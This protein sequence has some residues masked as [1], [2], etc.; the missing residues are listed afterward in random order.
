[1]SD[2]AEAPWFGGPYAPPIPY[3]E[4][5]AEKRNF[6]GCLNGAIVYG[7]VV[8]LFFKCMGALLRPANRTGGIMKWGLVAHTGAMFSFLTILVATVLDIQS[9]SYI[10]NR[11]FP[12]TDGAPW[13]GPVAYQLAIYSKAISVV[14][15]I[16]FLLNNW[17]ADGLL[18]YRCCVIY[19][20]KYWVIAFP[21]LMYLA[22][23]TL[24]ILF[25]YQSS[26][27]VGFLSSALAIADFGTPLF[28]ISL[29]LNV[30]LTLMIVARLFVHDRRLRKAT[31][32]RVTASGLYKALN[33]ILVESC[34]V[35]A[36][37]FL[38]YMGPWVAGS[39]IANIFFLP[40]T[41]AQVIA[42]FLLVL[43][44]A[45]RTAVTSDTMISVSGPSLYFRSKVE[46]IGGSETLPDAHH[47]GSIGTNGETP[48][49]HYVEDGGT[50]DEISL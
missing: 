23:F 10:D 33:T 43:R 13:A 37:S 26:R 42:P 5:I 24:G 18:L 50:I 36:I 35:Y 11:A 17:L 38:L 28:S 1:M 45:N 40:L 2:S 19:D 21:C 12:V 44:V 27:P 48:G 9:I 14:P 6:A 46:S 25:I 39:S 3:R 32:G 30:L 41:G 4:Y 47:V 49:H 29:S 15:V 8:V 7:I 20:M 34:A 16:M 31:G 22:S